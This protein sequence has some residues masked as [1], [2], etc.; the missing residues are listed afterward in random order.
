MITIYFNI[1]LPQMVVYDIND[2]PESIVKKFGW[3]GRIRSNDVK[4]IIDPKLKDIIRISRRQD[5]DLIDGYLSRKQIKILG[6][7]AIEI[8]LQRIKRNPV[9]WIRRYKEMVFW[10]I[11]YDIPIVIASE[12]KEIKELKGPYEL[13]SIGVI[14]GMN[15]GRAKQA[16]EF[17]R[18]KY[19]F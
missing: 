15:H 10:A 16:L 3:E 7:V 9:L 5:V 17:I 13:I 11:K 12:A 2:L 18:K 8:N 4:K 1:P 19:N 14:L 6:N